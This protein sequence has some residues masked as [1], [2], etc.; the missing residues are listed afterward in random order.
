M[1]V[2]AV[3]A[4]GPYPETATNLLLVMLFSNLAGRFIFDCISESI[5]PVSTMIPCA[6]FVGV[7]L[8]I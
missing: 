3:D 1:A 6:L 2:Y 7:I 8:F 5:G 4:L